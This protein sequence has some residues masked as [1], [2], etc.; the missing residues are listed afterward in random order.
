M[1][2]SSVGRKFRVGGKKCSSIWEMIETFEREDY[3][4]Y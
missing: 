4:Y 2:L 1:I 3:L